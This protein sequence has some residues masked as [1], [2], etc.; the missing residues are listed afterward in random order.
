MDWICCWFVAVAAAKEGAADAGNATDAL[1][2]GTGGI[3]GREVSMVVIP[4][5]NADGDDVTIVVVGEGSAS[6]VTG[7]WTT[8]APVNWVDRRCPWEGRGLRPV[9]DPKTDIG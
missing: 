2:P 1:I 3:G 7:G 6:V 5:A 8:N 4:A 9:G